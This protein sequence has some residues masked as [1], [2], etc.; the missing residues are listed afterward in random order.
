MTTKLQQYEQSDSG[1]K[2]LSTYKPGDAGVWS[3]RN[4]RRNTKFEQGIGYY[5]GR[6]SDVLTLALTLPEFE[7]AGTFGAIE[8][9]N[10]VQVDS[11]TTAKRL[12]LLAKQAEL[13]D[14]LAE[15]QKQLIEWS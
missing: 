1:K 9:I 13:N 5:A 3:V 6:F 12:E 14:Q 4:E 11:N 15:V 7:S 8:R 10:Y 2:A